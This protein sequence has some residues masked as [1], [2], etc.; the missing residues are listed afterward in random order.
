MSIIAV[1][2]G[3]A[4]SAFAKPNLAGGTEEAGG[5]RNRDRFN[6]A[7]DDDWFVRRN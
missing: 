3:V 1:A 5:E 4:A 7:K 2:L 6:G